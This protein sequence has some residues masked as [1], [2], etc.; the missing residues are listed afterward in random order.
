MVS[1][2]I[3]PADTLKAL[4]SPVIAERILRDIGVHRLYDASVAE[5]MRIKGIGEVSAKRIKAAVNMGAYYQQPQKMTVSGP[6][7][8]AKI[9]TS[10]IA[11]KSREAFVVIGLNTK[12]SVLYTEITYNGTLSGTTLRICEIFRE[13]IIRNCSAICVG[14]NHPS[15]DCTASPE[16]IV[17]TK[18]VIEAGKILSLPVLDH[19][20][21]IPGGEKFYSMKE[22]NS[23]LF[24]S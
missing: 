5:L 15:G 9:V 12:N 23:Y 17:S 14:H 3:N 7:D 24:S 19:I 18:A 4:V 21:V 8:V 1:T 10:L 16:D 13:A 22:K 6:I 11:N 20:I 2:S